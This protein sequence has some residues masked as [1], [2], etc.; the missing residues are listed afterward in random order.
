MIP[1]YVIVL[2]QYTKIV[3]GSRR[4]LVLYQNTYTK[5]VMG[6]WRVFSR[7][8]TRFILSLGWVVGRVTFCRVRLVPIKWR[9]RRLT[10][11]VC[12]HR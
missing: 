12:D 7:Q 4:V 10:L 1:L 5:I 6:P 2:Y 11:M 8:Y 9:C 3:L